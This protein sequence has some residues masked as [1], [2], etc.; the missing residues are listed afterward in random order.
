VSV[1]EKNFAVTVSELFDVL[2]EPETL[3]RW[4]IGAR[5][6][7][8]VSDD[9]P[10][11]A[12]YFEHVVGFGPVKTTDV[13]TVSN[14][15]PPY[16]L[17]LLVRAR[18]FIEASVRFEITA[19]AGGCRLTMTETPVGIY[20]AISAIAQPLVRAR[21]EGSLDRLESLLDVDAF[22]ATPSHLTGEQQ[23]RRNAEDESPA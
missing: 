23:A 14:V 20:R 6:I 4:L 1:S 3:P 18:P 9:W 15:D 13:T 12:S 5:R 17:E 16:R 21:N 22:R 8:S 7:R 2:V 11:P 10:Q 19:I